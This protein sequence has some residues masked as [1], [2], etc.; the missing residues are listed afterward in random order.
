MIESLAAVQD[1]NIITAKY[2]RYVTNEENRGNSYTVIISKEQ[3]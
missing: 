2:R 1:L 3:R